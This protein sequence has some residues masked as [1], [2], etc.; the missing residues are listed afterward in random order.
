MAEAQPELWDEQ[1]LATARKEGAEHLAHLRDAGMLSV[2]RAVTARAV[3]LTEAPTSPKG[4]E[5]K[6]LHLI[7]HGQGFHSTRA[8]CACTP[9]P[10]R[11]GFRWSSYCKADCSFLRTVGA[12][13]LLGDI[14][15]QNGIEFSSTGT[16]L[17]DNNPYRRPELVDPPLTS[18]GRE[19]ARALQPVRA[20]ITDACLH[21][22]R[23]RV[24]DTLLPR[25]STQKIS[26]LSW[27]WSRQ[28]YGRHRQQPARLPT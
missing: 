5:T 26:K 2:Q 21:D 24:I 17:S 9:P 19:Q 6:V 16:D 23:T 13:D 1:A 10:Q 27:S 18:I 14:Y 7:R 22:P 15:R 11:A 3:P 28:W 4:S 25:V 12:A 20:S 8:F